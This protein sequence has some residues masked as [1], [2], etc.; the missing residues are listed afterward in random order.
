MENNLIKPEIPVKTPKDP[1]KW[2]HV[3]SQVDNLMWMFAAVGIYVLAK[4]YDIQELNVIAGVC[5]A[6][7]RHPNNGGQPK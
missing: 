3:R 5:V 6:K 7:M 4:K 2:A 1:N